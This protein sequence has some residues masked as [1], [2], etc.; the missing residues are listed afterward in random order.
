MLTK[1][2]FDLISRATSKA[3]AGLELLNECARK[4]VR[5][6]YSNTEDKG[7]YARVLFEYTAD[8]LKSPLARFFRTCGLSV[9]LDGK[10]DT[11]SMIGDVLDRTMQQKVF[12]KLESMNAFVLDMQVKAKREPK[13]QDGTWAEQADKA[14]ANMIARLKKDRPEVAGIV[15]QRLQTPA[16]WVAKLATLNPTPDEVL[17]IIETL[18]ALRAGDEVVL[19]AAA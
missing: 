6:A 7:E 17:A 19:K 13:P 9:T 1:S 8:G 15:N 18:K 2:E 11:L 3:D 5:K 16:P 4:A 12:D 10:R 14:I